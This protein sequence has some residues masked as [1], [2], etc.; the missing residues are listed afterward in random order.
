VPAPDRPLPPVI[1]LQSDELIFSFPQ[2]LEP[3][4][5]YVR[6][7]VDERL[8]SATTD[9]K[10]M[11]P[12]SREEVH[13]TFAACLPKISATVTFQRSLRLPVNSTQFPMPLGLGRFSVYPVDDFSGVPEAWRQRGGIMLPLHPTE[14]LWL[15]FHSD[16]PMALRIG[17]GGGCAV[18]G[19]PWATALQAAPQNYVVLG[20]QPW[21]DGFHAGPEIVRQF[22]ARPAGQGVLGVHALSGE[23]RW[24]GLQ[25]QAIPLRA[26]EFWRQILK[27]KLNARWDELMTPIP[28]RVVQSSPP[29]GSQP[30]FTVKAGGK[31]RLKIIEDLH[32]LPAWDTAL[33]SRCFAHLCLASDWQRLTGVLPPQ[34]PPTP[35]DYSAAGVPWVESNDGLPRPNS[36]AAWPDAKLSNTQILEALRREESGYAAVTPRQLIRLN[37]DLRQVVREY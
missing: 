28:H 22:V 12:S 5:K 31:L 23:E 29:L 14:A 4:R 36:K 26:T 11:L 2:L 35:E 13:R 1:E 37:P 30:G 32:G 7:W 27:D 3:L 16:Y 18:S 25:L 17:T 33:S 15:E 8:E 34:N 6:G 19:E 10:N 20:T 24:G 9:E 21:L